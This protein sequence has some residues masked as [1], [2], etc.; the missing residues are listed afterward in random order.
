MMT[1][2]FNNWNILALPAAPA[3][4]QMEFTMQDSVAASKSPWTSQAQILDWGADWWE[5]TASL[6][7]LTRSQA[8]AW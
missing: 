6:P 5:A 8:Q 1:G 7:S 2:I 3:F 4:S